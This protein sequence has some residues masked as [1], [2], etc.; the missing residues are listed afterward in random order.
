VGDPLESFAAIR[1]VV[2]SVDPLLALSTPRRLRDVLEVALGEQRMMARL[3]SIFGGLALLLAVIGLYGVLAQLVAQRRSE[4]GL[5]VALG[6][7]PASI[8]R[9]VLA[10]GLRL[11]VAGSVIGVVAAMAATRYIENQLFGVA[12]SD[13]MT[14]VTACLMFLAVGAVACLLPAR[15]ALRI[16]PT[17]ALR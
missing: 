15:R 4:I 3:V 16:D 14:M 7:E 8:V 1:R 9:L 13:P 6:A 17:T 12:P 10:Q 2:R 11:V 5:R